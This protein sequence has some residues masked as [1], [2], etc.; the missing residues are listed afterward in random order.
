MP[1]H[2]GL[3]LILLGHRR[4]L[5]A[6]EESKRVLPARF[7]R[8]IVTEIAAASAFWRVEEY[9][10]NHR[11]VCRISARLWPQ[12]GAQADLGRQRGVVLPGS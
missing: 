11:G 3:V 10:Q 6:A 4:H 7:T 8:P 9:Y 12:C 5:A 2:F 1:E